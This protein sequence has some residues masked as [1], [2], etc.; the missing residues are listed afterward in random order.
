VTDS[1]FSSI[2]AAAVHF[3]L[4][5]T[6]KGYDAATIDYIRMKTDLM[7]WLN[8]LTYAASLAFSKLSILSFYWRIF[9]HTVIRFPIRFLLVAVIIWLLLRTF[10][11]IFQCFPPRYIWDKTIDGHCMVDMK[12]FFLSTILTHCLL[13]V[14]I[15]VLPVIPVFQMHLSWKSKVGVVLLFAAGTMYVL[16]V[17]LRIL[18]VNVTNASLKVLSLPPYLSSSSP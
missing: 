14:I 12:T 3:R 15:L 7:L 18:G 8:E 17:L 10:M 11:V 9:K 5:Q 6:V 4:G 2:F 13:D 1:S 16:V